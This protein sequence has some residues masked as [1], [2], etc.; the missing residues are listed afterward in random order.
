MSETSEN[1]EDELEM[2]RCEGEGLGMD[3]D[4]GCIKWD[5]ILACRMSGE[6]VLELI[7]VGALTL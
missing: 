6:T 4:G 7:I 1:E 3:S 2:E 5:S